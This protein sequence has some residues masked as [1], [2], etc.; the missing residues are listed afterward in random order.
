MFLLKEKS[1]NFSFS[2]LN[3]SGEEGVIILDFLYL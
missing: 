1:Q 3:R 2:M